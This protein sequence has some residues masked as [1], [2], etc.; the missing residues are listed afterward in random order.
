MIS[1]SIIVAYN[2]KRVIGK[3]NKLPWRDKEDLQR[4]KEITKG[5]PVIMGRI[6]RYGSNERLAGG[7]LDF[8]ES[9]QKRL[10]VLREVN[11]QPDWPLVGCTT[12]LLA[13]DWW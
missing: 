4:F 6:V 11:D 9:G 1:K 2:K 12:R 10:R 3:D 13:G 7:K 5:F 8:P